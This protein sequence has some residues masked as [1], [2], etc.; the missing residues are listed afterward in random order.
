MQ[1]FLAELM[2]KIAFF[3]LLVFLLLHCSSHSSLSL[4]G[5]N[6]GKLEKT[7]GSEIGSPSYRNI[8]GLI[9]KNKTSCDQLNLSLTSING[10][11]NF[12]KLNNNCQF[13]IPALTPAIYNLSIIDNNQVIS[14]VTQNE[15]QSKFRV[16]F[17]VSEGNMDI[18][19]G[20]IVY[21]SEAFPEFT[22]AAQNDFD[23]DGIDD[24]TDTDD[25]GDSIND[26]SD[27]CPWTPNSDQIDSDRDSWGDACDLLENRLCGNGLVEY[28]ADEICDENSQFCDSNCL[29]EAYYL[30]DSFPQSQ[31]PFSKVFYAE[32]PDHHWYVFLL[33]DEIRRENDPEGPPLDSPMQSRLYSVPTSGGQ[34]ILLS[35]NINGNIELDVIDFKVSPDS[36]TIIYRG[37]TEVD[38]IYRLYKVPVNG[39]EI[40]TISHNTDNNSIDDV[41]NFDISPSSQKVIYSSH[42]NERDIF[43]IDLETNQIKNLTENI[44]LTPDRINYDSIQFTE[45]ENRVLIED[46]NLLFIVNIDGS[47]PVI[48]NN[49][50]AGRR[51]NLLGS[52]ELSPDGQTVYFQEILNNNEEIFRSYI[53]SIDGANLR[54]VWPI[55]DVP[56]VIPNE[57][58]FLFSGRGFFLNN[59]DLI[60]LHHQS[61]QKSEIVKYNITNNQ[62]QFLSD[63]NDDSYYYDFMVSPDRQWMAYYSLVE[64]ENFMGGEARRIT[65]SHLHEDKRKIVNSK[66]YFSFFDAF[67]GF[68]LFFNENILNYLA[69]D[70]NNQ[71]Q[72]YSY[73]IDTNKEVCLSKNDGSLL[74][75]NTHFFLAFHDPD[76]LYY[77]KSKANEDGPELIAEN[78]SYYRVTPALRSEEKAIRLPNSIFYSESNENSV[79][80]STTGLNFYK[81]NTQM[82]LTA[83]KT[84]NGELRLF[85]KKHY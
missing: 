62:H 18:N 82:N 35:N 3:N 68:R 40:Q 50:E 61:R 27:N 17:G 36:N 85:I 14:L 55:D 43:C 75:E 44:D 38:E 15:A 12:Y 25:D 6:D 45:N 31:V 57:R 58:N 9:K 53:V 67:F 65:L 19:L 54:Q 37:D 69:Y 49:A 80:L 4:K 16:F 20:E 34:P 74:E 64:L 39:G 71:I 79:R 22:P 48:L 2:I 77:M 56:Q 13:S 7:G 83:E 1:T 84:P 76:Y 42:G 23:N 28:F 70:N 10:N 29:P 24:L 30:F 26:I 78:Q 73:F 72:L 59:N 5:A 66:P 8:K 41:I 47:N 63:T 21:G 51:G 32:S 81:S 11:Q 46:G 33:E 52:W 60:I